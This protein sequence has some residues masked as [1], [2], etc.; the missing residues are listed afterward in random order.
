MRQMVSRKK[1]RIGQV[2]VKKCVSRDYDEVIY[3]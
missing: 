1:M 3:C 2:E